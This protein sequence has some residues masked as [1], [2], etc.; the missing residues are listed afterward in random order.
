MLSTKNKARFMSIFVILAMLFSFANVSPAAAQDATPPSLPG[1]TQGT[2]THFELLDSPYLPVTLD[3]SISVTL[4]LS[5]VP[6]IVDVMIDPDV[7][8]GSADFTFGG[9][10]PNTLYYHYV[11]EGLNPVTFTTDDTGSFTYTQDRSESHHVWF[12]AHPS[13]KYLYDNATGGDCNASLGT[14]SSATK[15]CT[16]THNVNDAIFIQNNGITLDGAGKQVSAPGNYA[17]YSYGFSNV[18]IKNVKVV[19]SAYGIWSAQ[20]SYNTVKDNTISGTTYYGIFGPYNNS[21]NSTVSGN[22][23]SG[24]QY[25]GILGP[26]YQ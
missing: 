17:V 25:Y 11:D 5:S 15:T 14:W 16:L 23:I 18:T 26:Y 7:A 20:G 8:T 1:W 22:V 9:F 21:N 6:E 24:V 3:S 10:T 13:T 2:G 19:S 12:R 4:V